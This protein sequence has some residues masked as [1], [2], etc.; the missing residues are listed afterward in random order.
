MNGDG[1][2]IVNN[3]NKYNGNVIYR[4]YLVMSNRNVYT[5]H[6]VCN[7]SNIMCY[8]VRSFFAFYFR[9]QIAASL[10]TTQPLILSGCCFV[11]FMHEYFHVYCLL[12]KIDCFQFPIQCEFSF[13]H[14]MQKCI[15]CF[16]GR[17]IQKTT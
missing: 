7:F 14:V 10:C 16:D 9:F 1:T 3:N 6:H 4:S 15:E 5:F 12:D 8:R 17:K 2:S 13:F 11:S